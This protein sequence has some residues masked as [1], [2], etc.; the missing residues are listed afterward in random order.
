MASNAQQQRLRPPGPRQASKH[1][2]SLPCTTRHSPPR[3]AKPPLTGCHTHLAASRVRSISASRCTFFMR[4]RVRLYTS[5]RSTSSRSCWQCRQAGQA[6]RRGRQAGGAGRQ[7]GQAGRR[8]RQAGGAGRQAAEADGAGGA[9]RRGR[10]RRW[11]RQAGQVT[12]AGRW[13]RQGRQAG[14][15]GQA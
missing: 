3:A 8:R 10:L 15:A 1:P 7:A 14:Q 9:G 4:A 13:C 6:G 5:C 12:L 11:C 2:P